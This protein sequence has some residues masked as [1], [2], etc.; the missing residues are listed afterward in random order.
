MTNLN[1]ISSN[2]DAVRDTDEI[3]DQDYVPM[4]KVSILARLLGIF[5]IE[6]NF[7]EA[8]GSVWEDV[9]KPTFLDGCRDS[10]YTL[11]DYFFG[12]GG[13]SSSRRRSGK[14]TSKTPYSE[15]FKGKDRTKRGSSPNQ[16]AYFVTW[17]DRTVAL[18]KLDQMWDVVNQCEFCSVQDFLTICGKKTNNYTL[19]DWGWYSNDLN[20][21]RPVRTSD[22]DFYLNLPKPKAKDD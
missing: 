16:A 21:V 20:G 7:S 3:R 17:D 18:E 19:G 1:D 5:G 8:A 13:G 22:G 10:M 15:K 11:A 14:N 2:S 12:G 6:S 4:Q 9:I